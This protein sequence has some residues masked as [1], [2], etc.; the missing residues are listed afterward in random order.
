MVKEGRGIYRAQNTAAN[1]DQIAHATRRKITENMDKDPAF[2]QKF[3]KLIQEA[4]DDFRQQRILGP[5]V[6]AKGERYS[7]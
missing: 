4:I 5:R 3:S 2:Y 7:R 6:S 1:A